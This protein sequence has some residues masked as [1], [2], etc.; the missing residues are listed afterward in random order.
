MYALVSQARPTTFTNKEM[1]Q[2]IV[3]TSR[4][5]LMQLDRWRNQVSHKTLKYPLQSVHTSLTSIINMFYSSCSRIKY[6]SWVFVTIFQT[7]IA[8]ETLCHVPKYLWCVA[9]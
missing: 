1:A 6:V 4:V 7:V 2:W 9:C 8:A 3:N 5:L